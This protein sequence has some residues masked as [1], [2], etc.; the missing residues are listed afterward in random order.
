MTRN[1]LLC[2]LAASVPPAIADDTTC[3]QEDLPD[4]YAWPW[5][6]A[7]GVVKAGEALFSPGARPWTEGGEAEPARRDAA[8]PNLARYS[9]DTRMPFGKH[10]D[11]RVGDLPHDYLQFLVGTDWCQETHPGLSDYCVRAL[12]QAGPVRTP[13]PAA[14]WQPPPPVRDDAPEYPPF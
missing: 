12:G 3:A 9:D 6:Y 4:R 13:A 5:R 7:L 10:R 2:R 14:S 8:G 1:E 11:K